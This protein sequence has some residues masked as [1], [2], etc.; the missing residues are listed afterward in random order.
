MALDFLTPLNSDIL[1]YV[2]ELSSQHLGSKIV[3]HTHDDF[4]DLKKIKIAIIGVLENRGSEDFDQYVNLNYIRKEFFNLYP[5]NWNISIGDLGN[6]E[7]GEKIEDTYFAVQKLTSFLLKNNII[8]I[9][10]G[11]SQDITYPLYRAYDDLEQMVNVISIDNK[12]DFSREN[13]VLSNS[14]L[15]KMIVEEPNNLFN[16]TNIGYQTYFNSQEEIDLIEKLF[17]ESYRLGEISNDPTISEPVFRDGNLVSIDLNS[18][19][20]SDSGNFINFAPNGFSGK[21]ICSLA[22]YAGISDK[23]TCLG[24]INHQNTKQES[25]LI[26]QILWYFIEGIHCR[27][28]EYPFGSKQDYIKYIVTLEEDLVFYKSNITNRW[29]IEISNIGNKNN[30]FKKTT[31]FP[32]SHQDYLLACNGEVPERWWKN[33]RKNLI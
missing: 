5:G 6:I 8:P 19:K 18:I 22:R 28:N 14:Y 27:S 2:K 10:I 23:V 25:F 31:L 17:F 15:T 3:F 32:C 12:F 1:E 33:Q 11:G 21:E 13:G 30:K 26:S 24:M 16:Y 29:W 20:S 9:V 7:P 4:P